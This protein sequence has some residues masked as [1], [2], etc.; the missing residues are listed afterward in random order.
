MGG[1]KRIGERVCELIL[2][3]SCTYDLCDAWRLLRFFCFVSC[4]VL[5]PDAS[6]RHAV[7]S[8]LP[9]LQTDRHGGQLLCEGHDRGF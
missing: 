1:K 8:V 7:Y 5:Y 2:G 4:F 9:G 3:K 6:E